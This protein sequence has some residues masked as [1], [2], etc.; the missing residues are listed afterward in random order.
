MSTTRIIRG[1]ALLATV[2]CAVKAQTVD[3]TARTS[4]TH[5]RVGG[6]TLWHDGGVGL[7]GLDWQPAHSRFGIRATADY[8][9]R[10]TSYLNYSPETFLRTNAVD[11]TT[12]CTDRIRRSLSGVSV[13]AKYDL[14]T[15]RFR[16]YV[17]SGFGMYR[18]VDTQFMNAD[19]SSDQFN[20]R[21]TPGELHPF[22]QKTFVAS[23]QSGA[24]ASLR[25]KGRFE[26]YGEL[27]W[28]ALNG[29]G[30]YERQQWN[31]PTTFGFRF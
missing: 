2:N 26:L 29:F 30:N 17:F 14:L 16:P 31:G 27:T 20:C 23:M 10:T 21:L 18:S 22:T 25:I 28:R 8:S 19:C 11:C 13:D 12:F 3:T 1:F 6:G 9:R 5:I 4:A 15:G 24:G 7:V